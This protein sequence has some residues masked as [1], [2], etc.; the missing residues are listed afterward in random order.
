MYL[1]VYEVVEL[2][3]VHI[4]DCNSVIELLACSSVINS[5]LAVLAHAQSVR[6][7]DLVHCVESEL[8]VLMLQ[9]IL[10]SHFEAFSDV[11]LVSTVEYRGHYLPAK[12]LCR[13]TKMNL[14]HLTDV[15]TRRYAQWVKTDI[16]RSTVLK[17]WHILLWEYS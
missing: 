6:V 16:K 5:E 1:I 10:L 17:E 13:H 9:I 14:K 7:D 12:S 11:C 3:V 2:Q 4:T 8:I 15:H